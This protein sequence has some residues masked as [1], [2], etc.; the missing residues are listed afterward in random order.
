[1]NHHHLERPGLDAAPLGG[2]RRML[3]GCITFAVVMRR[4]CITGRAI[5][6]AALLALAAIGT[7]AQDPTAPDEP[8]TTKPEPPPLPLDRATALQA[9]HLAEIWMRRGEAPESTVPI[10][11]TDVAGVQVT[12]RMDQQKLGSGMGQSDDPLQRQKPVDVMALVLTAMRHAL[13]ET[14]Q[15]MLSIDRGQAAANEPF[16]LDQ[17]ADRLQLD[18]QFA[19]TPRPIRIQ[20]LDELPAQFRINDHGLAMRSP[21]GW[22]WVYPGTAISTNSGF[23]GQITRLMGD[24]RIAIEQQGKVAQDGGPPLFYFE[25]IHLLRMG[26]EQP[27]RF[28]QRGNDVESLAEQSDHDLFAFTGRLA[29]HLLQRQRVD[30]RFAGRYLPTSDEYSPPTADLYD[31]ALAVY[32]LARTAR[33]PLLGADVERLSVAA[34]NGLLP[35]LGD[36]QVNA[37]PATTGGQAAI[38]ANIDDVAMTL[39]A[40]LETPNAGNLKAQREALAGRLMAMQT[41]E[42]SFRTT[43]R[44][45]G[46]EAPIGSQ[47]R[48][49]AALVQLYDRTRDA[50][51]GK[52]ARAALDAVWVQSQGTRLRQALPWL[53]QAE[54]ELAR[55]GEPAPGLLTIRDELCPELFKMQVRPHH[56]G[57]YPK[58]EASTL[59]GFR[60]DA[61]LLDEPTAQSAI[62][63]ASLA[64]A[65]RVSDFVDAADRPRWIVALSGGAQFLDRLSIHQANCF[66]VKNPGE[67]MGG[68]RYS[69]WDNR[70]ALSTTAEALVAVVEL[71]QS[72]LALQRD[73]A[74][75][76]KP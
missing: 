68:V 19:H 10:H 50:R 36:L 76:K 51:F 26:R 40:L 69:Y 66:Y 5:T 23:Q 61:P 16:R 42:G 12:I 53:T 62:P 64:H 6:I 14:M 24:L 41:P 63:L 8:P 43:L 38:N 1:M 46:R 48:A 71:Q 45:P 37:G 25:A 11:A 39:L 35:L 15:T 9:F 4:E 47:A 32:A 67:A 17:I 49:A 33:L 58:A 31:S 70:L 18:M 65:L 2:L 74:A 54:F 28:M 22:A 73:Q 44:A 34:R 52:A 55:L 72:L 7:T 20:R 27:I 75:Q 30:G 60:T 59:G 21:L 56:I 3:R 13:A 57:P 29:A